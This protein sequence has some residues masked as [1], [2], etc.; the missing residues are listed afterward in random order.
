MWR[1]LLRTVAGL[2]RVAPHVIRW[3]NRRKRRRA[4]KRGK[5]PETNNT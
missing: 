1:K 4:E 2:V 5:P 3:W